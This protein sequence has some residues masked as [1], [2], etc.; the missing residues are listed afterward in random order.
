[1]L[2]RLVARGL[3]LKALEAHIDK[4]L[5]EE[6][7]GHWQLLNLRGEELLLQC[8]NTAWATRLRFMQAE[9]LRRLR[10]DGM[11]KLRTIRVRV[12][13]KR[14]PTEA[15]TTRRELSERAA[16]DIEAAAEG[17]PDELAAALRRLA[18]RRRTP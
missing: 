2:P 15:P 5:P 16:A 10:E 9:L 8:E 7:Q 17:M 3:R 4:C 11:H 6:F 13:P 12:A 1:M 18:G 14:A